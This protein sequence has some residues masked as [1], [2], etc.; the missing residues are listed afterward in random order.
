MRGQNGSQPQPQ[1]GAGV[2]DVQY[3][4]QAEYSRAH[5][6]T[7]D[8]RSYERVVLARRVPLTLHRA[9]RRRGNTTP[10]LR[11]LRIWVLGRALREAVAATGV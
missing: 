6:H 10:L 3:G 9:P 2:N 1:S 7:D 8:L 4:G 5:N 11:L